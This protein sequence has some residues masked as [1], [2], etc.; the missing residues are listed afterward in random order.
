MTF[1]RLKETFLT[2][3]KYHKCIG[4]GALALFI[5]TLLPWYAD[6]DRYGIGDEF[7]GVTGPTSFVGIGIL[8]LSG[9]SLWLFAQHVWQRR[10]PRLPIQENLVH[11]FVSLE[12]LFLLLLV[13][14]IFF[15]S[16]FGVNITLKESRF[17]MTLAFIGALALL[18]GSYWYSKEEIKKDEEIGHLE[19]LIK[20]EPTPKSPPPS[21]PNPAPRPTYV[22]QHHPIQNKPSVFGE[23][24]PMVFGDLQK[25]QKPEGKKKEPISKEPQEPEE[26][27]KKGSYMIR[28][29]L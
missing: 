4:I 13:N 27:D 23:K 25:I 22:R 24:R 18:I 1:A 26:S 2:L 19:P 6:R 15:H 5:S 10:I 9:L 14:S 16:K 20:F 11:L 28:M 8:L 12:S 29:D 21:A 7:L 3:P 17:G